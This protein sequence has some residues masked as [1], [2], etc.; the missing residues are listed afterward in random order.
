MSTLPSGGQTSKKRWSIYKICMIPVL[1]NIIP[2]GKHLYVICSLSLYPALHN[3][4]H[5][6][7]FIH[8]H[9]GYLFPTRSHGAAPHSHFNACLSYISGVLVKI[10]ICQL[11]GMFEIENKMTVV[12][13]TSSLLCTIP[14]YVNKQ[15]NKQQ[16]PVMAP[17]VA[18]V[19]HTCLSDTP[20]TEISWSNRTLTLSNFH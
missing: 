15:L 17:V 7:D 11:G 14:N 12:I 3:A 20:S 10:T 9:R 4:S 8:N 5:G 13:I 19:L 16:A 2:P 18:A 6:Y 1:I